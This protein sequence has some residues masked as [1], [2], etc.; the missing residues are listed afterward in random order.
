MLEQE[1]PTTELVS[2]T[3][4]TAARNGHLNVLQYMS[5]IPE[6]KRA[7]LTTIDS[8]LMGSNLLMIVT[9]VYNF[10]MVQ[11]ILENLDFDI[12][13]VNDNGQTVLETVIEYQ[14]TPPIFFKMVV[15]LVVVGD[16]DA[17]PVWRFFRRKWTTSVSKLEDGEN[18]MLQ[19][20]IKTLY[21]FQRPAKSVTN[22]LRATRYVNLVE[23]ADEVRRKVSTRKTGLPD[24]INDYLPPDLH[25]MVLD[26]DYV[27]TDEMWAISR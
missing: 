26:M 4:V 6:F 2:R 8:Q 7:M 9:F 10:E 27:T 24:L 25:K 20:F 18:Q 1:E 13:V 5:M 23:E 22:A 19:D 3:V 11:W 16:A 14:Q 21:L 15:L 12:E 17:A